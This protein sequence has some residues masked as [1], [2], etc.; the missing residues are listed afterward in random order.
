MTMTSVRSNSV[1][2]SRRSRCTCSRICQSRA[3]GR[4]RPLRPSRGISAMPALPSRV[5]GRT[6]GPGRSGRSAARLRRR[7][8][9]RAAS[10]PASTWWPSAASLA[11]AAR[12]LSAT[13]GVQRRGAQ[14]FD[15]EH[16]Q[17]GAAR[18]GGCVAAYAAAS[19]ERSTDAGPR[20]TVEQ[21]ARIGHRARQR[22][23]D[24]EVQQ[25]ARQHVLARH[26]A[27]RGL[28][29][30]QAGVRGRAAGS[31]RRRPGRSPAAR[32]RSPRPPPRRRWSRPASAAHSRDC[33]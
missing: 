26:G 7:N 3:A 20:M 22:T 32:C 31:S 14:A 15:V 24:L 30:D 19:E 29:A 28:E 23:D 11:T 4:R 18:R 8:P 33:R 10:A 13:C 12:T 9:G 6:D 2:L 17:A 27:E 25:Q 21:Q 16:A 1:A 5:G